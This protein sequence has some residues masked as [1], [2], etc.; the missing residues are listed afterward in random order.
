V[1]GSHVFVDETKRRGY[2]LVAGVVLPEDLD[3]VRRVLR[4]LVLPGQRRLHMKDESDSR[5]RSIATAI[6]VSD[7]QA[8]IYDAGRR[9]RKNANAAR[10]ACAP[11]S[12]TPPDAETPCSYSS[13]TTHWSAGTTS[14]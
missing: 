5:K 1:S 13:K 6:S 10:P 7:V 14:T 2:L 3:G 9:Y 12:K 11:L 4:G 8:T